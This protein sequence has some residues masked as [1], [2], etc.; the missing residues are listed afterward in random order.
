MNVKEIK[1][2]EDNYHKSQE[3]EEKTKGKQ[4]NSLHILALEHVNLSV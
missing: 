4:V 1:K 2:S 3:E